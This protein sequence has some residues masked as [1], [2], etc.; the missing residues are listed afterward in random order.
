M[1]CVLVT[2]PTPSITHV[3]LNRPHKL[4]ALTVEYR[5]CRLC[6][7][8]GSAFRAIQADSQCKAVVF[9]A[10]GRVFSAGLD[11]EQYAVN[12]VTALVPAGSDPARKGLNFSG[13]VRE[14]QDCVT[15]IEACG[16]PVLA[17]VHGVCIGEANS[18]I[19]ACDMRYFSA[20]VK[21]S[22]KDPDLGVAADMGFLQ[23]L[24][25]IV[26]NSSWARE[27][28][29][30]TRFAGAQECLQFGLCA[31]VCPDKVAT[32]AAAMATAQEIAASP[33]NVTGVKANLN[34]SRDHSVADSL[35]FAAVLQGSKSPKL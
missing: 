17:A 33:T 22:L 4:N 10:A 9:S 34:Y 31:Q 19:T 26:G 23:R 32:I 25:R 6:R 29:Y 14:I 21:V 16:K 28:V 5:S 1:E 11:C 12:E 7:A 30:T 24:E 35:F 27:M 3:Q 8:V 13:L 20:D 15:A 18:F 2:Q